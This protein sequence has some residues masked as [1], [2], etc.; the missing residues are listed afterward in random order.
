MAYHL[1]GLV[2]HQAITITALY[3]R[4]NYAERKQRTRFRIDAGKMAQAPAQQHCAPCDCNHC[5][6]LP[7]LTGRSVLQVYISSVSGKKLV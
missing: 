2:C 3:S 6:L 7:S 4:T 1:A 5:A